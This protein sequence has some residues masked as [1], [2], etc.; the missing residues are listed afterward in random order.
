MLA[1]EERQLTASDVVEWV[2]RNPISVGSLCPSVAS[3]GKEEYGRHKDRSEMHVYWRSFE[4]IWSGI[5]VWW[6]KYL[7]VRVWRDGLSWRDG[8]V[9]LYIP[10]HSFLGVMVQEW[11]AFAR[12]KTRVTALSLSDPANTAY[13]YSHLEWW[14]RW[15]MCGRCLKHGAIHESVLAIRNPFKYRD[16][17]E[18]GSHFEWWLRWRMCWRCLEHG[19][20]YE[21]FLWEGIFSS[22]ET[23]MRVNQTIVRFNLKVLVAELGFS[24]RSW[25]SG[26][27]II[28]A[29]P[30]RQFL[31]TDD[32]RSSASACT[33]DVVHIRKWSSEAMMSVSDQIGEFNVEKMSPN[34]KWVFLN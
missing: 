14:L 6:Y 7:S 30:R 26:Q 28:L 27:T 2:V 34:L 25:Q 3:D 33:A 20:V 11:K 15:R 19:A 10:F 1:A 29:A 9:H 24:R 16:C 18:S 32:L 5:F 17:N 12:S 8:K 4:W 21:F 22:I 13:K 23:A 31:R